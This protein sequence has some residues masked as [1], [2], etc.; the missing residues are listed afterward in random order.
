MPLPSST[1]QHV[2]T[3]SVTQ[4]YASVLPRN[5]KLQECLPNLRPSGDAQQDGL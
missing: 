1:K 3:A 4:F 2:G 5:T